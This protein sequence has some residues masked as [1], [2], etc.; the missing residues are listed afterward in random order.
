MGDL[1][2]DVAVKDVFMQ[3]PRRSRG[4]SALSLRN[5]DISMDGCAANLSHFMFPISLP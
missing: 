2:Y 5:G 1:R 3:T 4:V